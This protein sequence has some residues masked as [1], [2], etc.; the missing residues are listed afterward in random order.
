MTLRKTPTGVLVRCPRCSGRCKVQVR[1]GLQRLSTV[2]CPR[3]LGQ[4]KIDEAR[5]L[6][7]ER[8]L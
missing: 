4:G 7:K 2:I 6:K 8:A 3:C 1:K 5:L